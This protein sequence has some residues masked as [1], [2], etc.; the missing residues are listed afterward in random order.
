MKVHNKHK[1]LTPGFYHITS[2][3]EKEPCLVQLY[4]CTHMD[5]QLVVGFNPHDGMAIMPVWDF[6]EETNF[7]PV[8][9]VAS[10][11]LTAPEAVYGFAAWLTCRKNPIT[12]S[13]TNDASE[14]CNLVDE[15][16]KVN[17]LGD[18]R[19]NYSDYL[20]HPKGQ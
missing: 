16:L 8:S 18:P 4:H 6:T 7:T 17:S 12:L 1:D 20:T 19:D 9:I 11:K 2:E 15:F 5:G 14:I 3:Q 13:S 10:D